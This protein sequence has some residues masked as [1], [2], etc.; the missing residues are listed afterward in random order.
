M[1][2]HELIEGLS[3]PAAFEP[4][5][6][7]VE[8]RQTHISVVALAGPIVYKVKKP[9]RLG[10]ADYGTLG[11]RKHFCEEE[12]RLN[13]RLAAGVYLG[14]VPIALE[15]GRLRVEG[16]GEPVEWAVKMERLPD[17]ATL[18]SLVERDLAG[19]ALLVELGRRLAGF[20][21]SATRGERISSLAGHGRL[22][23]LAEENFAQ[24]AGHVGLTVSPAVFD[25]LKALTGRAAEDLRPLIE[26]RVAR[27]I[28][29]ETHGDLRP[30]H[31]Y[32]LP[33]RPPPGDIAI[34]DCVEFNEAYRAADP[35]ADVA[36]LI[37]ELIALDRPDLAAAI[38]DAYV[39]AS[40]D[41]EVHRLLP[42][43][44]S[45]RAAV[46][47]KVEGMMA[48][49]QEVAEADR[50]RALRRARAHWLVALAA[51]EAPGLRPCLVLVG[52]LPGS[53]KST[54]AR[55]LAARGGFEVIRS[56]AVRKELA[57]LRP[58][59]PAPAA[60]GEGLYTPDG[61]D[62]TY[63]ECFDRAAA[64]IREGKRVI[65]DASF[66]AEARRGQ[67]LDLAARSG[68][69]G[70]F[71]HCEAD[72]AV[73]DGRLAARRGDA[74]DADGSILEGAIAAWEPLG[75]ATRRKTRPIETGG[76]PEQ[77]LSAAAAELTRR[78]LWRP[79][80]PCDG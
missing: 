47:G 72:R 38:R 80:G 42:F 21:A 44:V 19:Q 49:A 76:T 33:D 28:P 66:R 71:L 8:V 7:R 22:R 43:F 51:L 2:L 10:F 31:V 40:G 46:R 20:H 65:V 9:V 29:C 48:A 5:P 64:A 50:A 24:A 18:L 32:I 17:E 27:G 3:D 15:G 79:D 14:V 16:R 34:I 55:G 26:G 36:F 30:E 74:S 78:G 70:L 60:F 41:L 57:G 1:D 75:E 69:A 53:G 39:S 4:R 68:V 37:M 25:R 62:R 58:E 35:A 12:V 6:D 23:A 56:D 59:E 52:G 67:F 45:Y 13:R 61:D 54:L 63:R 77:A 73:V 11:L